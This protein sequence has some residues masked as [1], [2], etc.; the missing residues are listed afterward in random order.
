MTA[1]ARQLGSRQPARPARSDARQPKRPARPARPA[2]SDLRRPE[3]PGRPVRA[4]AGWMP[5]AAARRLLWRVV[6]AATGG[7][8]VAGAPPRRP[9]VLVANH[10]SHADTAAL[11]AAL[12]ARRRPAVVAAA[13][14]WFEGRVRSWTGRALAAAVP[15]R[16]GGGGS[17]DLAAAGNLLAAGRDV[18]VFAEGTRS[19]DGSVGAFRG[20]AARLATAAGV[21][22]VP[23]AISGTRDLLPAHGRLRRARV[24]VRFGAPL[25][26][27]SD[28]PAAR[29]AV[30]RLV[31]VSRH[32]AADTWRRR[33]AARIAAVAA[34]VTTRVAAVATTVAA[35]IAGLGAT[36]AAG[37]RWTPAR[38]GV[39]RNVP[40][41][42]VRRRM[43]RLAHGRLGVAAVAAWSFAEAL[44][45]PL[46]PEFALAVLAVAAPR[47]APRLAAVAV[48]A[49]LAGGVTGYGLG[50]AGLHPPAPLTTPLMRATVVQAVAEHGAAAVRAQP[51][52]G[53][54]YKVYAV[55]AGA[56]HVDLGGFLLASA[57]GRG[58]R[59]TLVG[60]VLG[61][62]GALT[63]RWRRW[64]PLY[65]VV[66]PVLF[67]A[68]LALV[69]KSWS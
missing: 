12:P 50:A 40:D 68:G 8:R 37:L 55:T 24:Q 25:P 26:D 45:W 11:L 13:D 58:S 65:L 51:T 54:P 16:R 60:L 9:C 61:L 57:T 34:A 36:V 69:V 14:Y 39:H 5:G 49:S 48:A 66:F 3:R 44:S 30:L 7:L 15:V 28:V 6:L 52:S 56:A 31:S 33:A 67:A 4:G 2:W 43:A 59:I 19:R 38:G 23:V 1:P 64:Y 41:S 21:D 27:P 17:A 18:I 63:V 62:F 32:R 53:I 20:G 22:L 35:R 46:V 29:A 10:S 42:A 47:R